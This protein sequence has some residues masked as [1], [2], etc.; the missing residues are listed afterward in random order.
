MAFQ[1]K[2]HGILKAYNEESKGA[3][4]FIIPWPQRMITGL[5]KTELAMKTAADRVS[6]GWR[7][8][9]RA[10]RGLS[11]QCAVNFGGKS[12]P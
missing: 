5:E 3:Y 7:Q 2:H 12:L 9:A 11:L 1:K 10:S 8:G 4:L 6:S